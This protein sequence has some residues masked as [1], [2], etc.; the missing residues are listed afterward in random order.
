M[1]K[2]DQFKPIKDGSTPIT[3]HFTDTGLDFGMV[4]AGCH[5]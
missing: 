4:V 3:V 2:L 5:P 1:T